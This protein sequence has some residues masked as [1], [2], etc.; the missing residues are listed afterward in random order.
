MYEVVEKEVQNKN[1]WFSTRKL[2]TPCNKCIF[3]ILCSPIS[4]YE[5]SLKQNNLCNITSN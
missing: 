5:Y 4:E 2:V 1:G 3:N